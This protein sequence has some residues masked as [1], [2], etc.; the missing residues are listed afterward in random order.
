MNNNNNNNN[1]MYANNRLPNQPGY[2]WNNNF[3]WNQGNRRPEWYYN[4]A[5][6]KQ[7]SIICVLLC[8][9]YILMN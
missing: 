4:A 3:N 5:N 6:T 1:N 7:S 2:N 9:L 8:T